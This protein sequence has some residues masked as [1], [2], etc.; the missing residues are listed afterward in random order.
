[1]ISGCTAPNAALPTEDADVA[2]DLA[3]ASAPDLTPTESPDLSDGADLA[4]APK[5]DL[6]SALPDLALPAGDMAQ[7]G[8]ANEPCCASPP[9]AR[10]CDT[11]LYCWMDVC[12]PCGSHDQECCGGN[13]QHVGG[14]CV[15][16]FTC[17]GAASAS[18]GHCN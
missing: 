2:R 10:K 8:G 12:S 4:G 9:A 18:A 3:T 16:G 5:P 14:F 11:S 15:T 6:L 13:A 7:C 17:A 1:L